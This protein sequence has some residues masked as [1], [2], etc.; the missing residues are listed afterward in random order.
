M[1]VQYN[2]FKTFKWASCNNYIINVTNNLYPTPVHLQF[3][4]PIWIIAM[5]YGRL[6]ILK[7][8]HTKYDSNFTETQHPVLYRNF[9]CIAYEKA[10][11]NNHRNVIAWV[12][13]NK[14]PFYGDCNNKK[15]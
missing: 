10:I 12:C 13:D 15:C 7:W 5:E 6:N 11:A 14:F 8:L 9:Y 3:V 1:C 4:E 2:Y